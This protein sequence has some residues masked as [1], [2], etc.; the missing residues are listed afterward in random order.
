MVPTTLNFQKP[1]KSSKTIDQGAENQQKRLMVYVCCY[2]DEFKFFKLR[3]EKKRGRK[4]GNLLDL[5]A[6]KSEAFFAVR[7]LQ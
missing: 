1:L 2:S 5:P 3:K 4:R 7:R 6:P